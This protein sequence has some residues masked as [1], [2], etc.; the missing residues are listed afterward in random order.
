MK[1]CVIGSGIGGSILVN[2]LAKHRMFHVTVVDCD[3]LSD[4]FN[5]SFNLEKKQ[6]KNSLSKR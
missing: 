1:I 2:E 5:A 4:S 6:D 3:Y